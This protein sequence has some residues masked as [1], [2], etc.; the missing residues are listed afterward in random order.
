[1]TGHPTGHH[2][3]M[4]HQRR[5]CKLQGQMLHSFAEVNARILRSNV[6]DGNNMQRAFLTQERKIA[7]D[8]T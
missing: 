1:M 5:N 4:K 6:H 2:M 7:Q 8:E 3:K